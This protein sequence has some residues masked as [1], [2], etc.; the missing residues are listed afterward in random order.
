MPAP[1]P[2]LPLRVYL[3]KLVALQCTALSA[4]LKRCLSFPSLLLCFD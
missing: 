4:R 1:A 2:T 3:K